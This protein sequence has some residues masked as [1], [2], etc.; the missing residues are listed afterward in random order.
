MDIDQDVPKQPRKRGRPIGT[1]KKHYLIQNTQVEVPQQQAQDALFDDEHLAYTLGEEKLSPFSSL[2]RHI[3]HH[4]HIEIAR[5]AKDLEVAE[6]TVYR[7]MNGSS[8]PRA[9]H[10]KRLPEV[11]AEHR[12]NLTYA[13]NQT[14]PGV[15]DPPAL[16]IR[17]VRKDIYRRV[18]DLITTIPEDDARYWQVTQAIFE[19][20]LLHL[21]SDRRGL[22]ITYASL[23]PSHE[24][25]IHSLREAA[26]RGNYPWPFSLESRAYLGSTT[27]AGTAATLQRLQTWDTLDNEERLQ[28]DVDEHE[29]CAAACP[30]MYAGRI[31]GVLI[32]SSTQTGFFADSMA[33]Q[34]VS[35]YAQLLALAFRN[36]DFYPC[37]LLNLRPMPEVNWQRAEIGRSYV[38]R[39]ITYA[40]KHMIARQDAEQYVL[41]EMEREFEELE[42]HLNIQSKVE[43]PHK[44]E[45]C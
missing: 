1:K 41:I 43:Q 22:A 7:W 37:S 35:E 4:D 8:E 44:N 19:C 34:A 15:L 31:S 27:L 20:A 16:G 12:G 26:M 42:R 32:V 14:F 13:I 17:E 29:H 21:D 28:V 11:F 25:G 45:V 30:V 6:I 36:E 18:F 9:I 10:L 23:M 24:D 3:L 38:N 39:I 5:V 33:C 2:L 40:R